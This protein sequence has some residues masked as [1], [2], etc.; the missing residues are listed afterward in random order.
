MRECDERIVWVSEYGMS[1]V[2]V[3][4]LDVS[5]CGV[6]ECGYEYLRTAYALIHY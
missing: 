5:E 4:C 3:G 2:N 6:C 1:A